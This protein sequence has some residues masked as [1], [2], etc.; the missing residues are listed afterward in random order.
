MRGP[1]QALTLL[2]V[3]AIGSGSA[4]A[5]SQEP[6]VFGVQAAAVIV[7][8]VV[9]DKK[10]RL[11]RDLTAADFEAY[12]DGVKQT[13]ASFRVVDNAPATPEQPC[14]RVRPPPRRRRRA[15]RPR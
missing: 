14:R 2:L 12:E 10:G 3:A 1:S 11:V 9:R 15:A 7:D 4:P 6:P 5:G 13:L 8:V